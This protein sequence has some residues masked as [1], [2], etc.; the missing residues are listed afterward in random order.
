MQLIRGA[1]NGGIR[2]GSFSTEK[3]PGSESKLGSRDVFENRDSRL[4]TLG[5]PGRL[6]ALSAFLLSLLICAIS[7]LSFPA[8]SLALATNPVSFYLVVKKS[9]PLQSI[10]SEEVKRLYR[11][12]T[13]ELQGDAY[14]PTHF[15]LTDQT[16]KEFSESVLDWPNVVREEEFLRLIKFRNERTV[17]IQVESLKE[18]LQQVSSGPTV[19]Y[20][21]AEGVKLLPEDLKAIPIL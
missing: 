21:R 8:S 1:G 2:D 19:G 16:R 11:R 10:T 20:V 15:K 3:A 17:P 7:T 6:S 12:K 13:N 9:S 14:T 18:M 5:V 4:E